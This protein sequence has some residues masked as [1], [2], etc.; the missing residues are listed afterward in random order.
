MGNQNGCQKTIAMREGNGGCLFI[1]FLMI[2]FPSVASFF[3]GLF[4]VFLWCVG[5]FLGLC[6]VYG[7][8]WFLWWIL[9]GAYQDDAPETPK[10][11]T[12]QNQQ[13]EENSFLSIVFSLCVIFFLYGSGWWFFKSNL[14]FK[15]F[16]LR[17]WELLIINM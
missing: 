9:Y 16:W 12:E 1:L 13:N 2:I 14:S 6:V 8:C 5:I 15:E 17:K 10:Q 11:P 7:V 4:D 3:A